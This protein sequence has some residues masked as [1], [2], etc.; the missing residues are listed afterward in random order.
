MAI[1]KLYDEQKSRG[2]NPAARP[3]GVALK[4]LKRSILATTWSRKRKEYADR[5][6]GTLRDV[7]APAQI[8]DHTKVEWSERTEVTCALRI[9]V[10][11]LSGDH[12]LLRSSNRLPMEL[13]DCFPLELANEGFKTPGHTTKVLVV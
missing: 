9:E 5:G 6:V 1:Q 3:Q 12:M 10:D 8:P 2:I 4:A 11:F 13:P 7:Y